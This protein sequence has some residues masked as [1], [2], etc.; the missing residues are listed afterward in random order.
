MEAR[1]LAGKAALA[2]PRGVVVTRRQQRGPISV[3][4]YRKTPHPQPLLRDRDCRESCDGAHG[5]GPGLG[6]EGHAIIA[7]IAY[8]EPSVRKSSE[9]PPRCRYVLAHNTPYRW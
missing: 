9:H 7:L 8:L 2:L 4:R 6:D 3:T 5:T 1:H